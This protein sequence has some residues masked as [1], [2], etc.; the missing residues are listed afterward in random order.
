MTARS[1]VKHGTWDGVPNEVRTIWYTRDDELELL[2]GEPMPE[3]EDESDPLRERDAKVLANR[4][5]DRCRPQEARVL[6]MRY[7]EDMTLREIGD[8]LG[9]TQERI[10]QIEKKAIWRI[11]PRAM[12]DKSARSFF[13]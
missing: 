6:A 4:L 5:L 13:A 9:V 10:R 1:Y 7:L 8:A 2:S 3:L 12:S 11:L